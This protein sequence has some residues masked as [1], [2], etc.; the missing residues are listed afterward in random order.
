[1]AERSGKRDRQ[2]A[3]LQQERGAWKSQCLDA[4]VELTSANNLLAASGRNNARCTTVVCGDGKTLEHSMKWIDVNLE[5]PPTNVPVLC[6]GGHE[7][8]E[9]PI[10]TRYRDGRQKLAKLLDEKGLA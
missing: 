4:S 10:R 3:Q 2:I 8:F 1:M 6:W 9:G 7:W 5:H